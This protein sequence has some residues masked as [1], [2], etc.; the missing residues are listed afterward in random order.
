MQ[1]ISPKKF[2]DLLYIEHEIQFADVIDPWQERDFSALDSGWASVCGF[3]DEPEFTRAW[4][5]RKRGSSKS[6]DLAIQASYALYASP[7]RL[8][9]IVAAGDK[10]QAGILKDHL[11]K[12][13]LLK[14]EPCEVRR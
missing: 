14:V 13:I 9:G 6:T 5:E 3:D 7:R 4:I 10:E 11:A 2:R 12:I 8:R 1:R